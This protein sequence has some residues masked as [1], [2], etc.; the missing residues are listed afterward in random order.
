MRTRLYRT[1]YQRNLTGLITYT[2]FRRLKA[3]ISSL[4]K[5]ATCSDKLPIYTNR[6]AAGNDH[7]KEKQNELRGKPQNRNDEEENGSKKIADCKESTGSSSES[8]IRSKT[9]EA[10]S[11]CTR[12]SNRETPDD[13]FDNWSHQ[14][15]EDNKE[16]GQDEA[17]MAF[18]LSYWSKARAD[19]VSEEGA[20]YRREMERLAAIESRILSKLKA[21]QQY[22]RDKY[23]KG[24]EGKREYTDKELV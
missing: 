18:E 7:N 22:V 10:S 2:S 8:D 9:S 5:F 4:L 11:N 1:I 3:D 14:G 20:R 15:E 13:F 17:N 19:E 12:I 6:T 21:W 16:E 24:P 23:K